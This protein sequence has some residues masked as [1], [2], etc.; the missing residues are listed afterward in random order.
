MSKNILLQKNIDT[1]KEKKVTGDIAVAR[2][3]Q[4]EIDIIKVKKVANDIALAKA[5]QKKLDTK[6][7]KKVADNIALALAKSEIRLAE[8]NE[9]IK[10]IA[11]ASYDGRPETGPGRQPGL[12]AGRLEDR[13]HVRQP[14]RISRIVRGGGGGRGTDPAV[15]LSTR[16]QRRQNLGHARENQLPKR[17][18]PDL[19]LPLPARPTRPGREGAGH[20]VH[21]RRADRPVQR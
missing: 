12:V 1:E 20:H 16:G 15:L 3:K 13:L 19:R 8:N 6:K 4:K 18:L 14:H 11:K 7:E 17:C 10:Y 2:S 5:K 9:W 21:P